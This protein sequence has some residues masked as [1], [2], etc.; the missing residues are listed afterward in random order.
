MEK[1][2]IG[3]VISLCSG[4]LAFAALG[5]AEVREGSVTLKTY[6]FSDPDPVPA[7]ME[8]RYPYFRFD[9]SSA[10]GRPHAFSTVHMENRRISLDLMPDVG[11]KVW[12]ATDKESGFD[13]IYRNHAAKF[14]NIATRGPWWSGGIEYNFGIIGHSPCTSTPVDYVIR[15][16]AD[17]SVSCIIAMT[18]FIC[19]TT[20]QVEVRLG[21]NDGHFT[22]RTLW[23]NA[24]GLPAPCYHWMNSA[25]PVSDDMVLKFDGRNEIGHEGDAHPWPID[26]E[27]RRLSVY[28]NNAFGHNK[29]YHVINGDNRVF[30]VWYPSRQIGFIHENEP[31]EK[32]GRKAWLWALSREGAIWEDLLTDFDGQY[33]ELQSGR[34]FN[35]PRLNTV[36]TPFKHPT[37]TPGR[38]DTFVEKWGVVRRE[39]GYLSRGMNPPGAAEPRPVTAP[40]DFDWNGV[41]GHFLR[42]QQAIRERE[43]R[44]GERELCASLAIDPNFVPALDELAFL[45]IRRGRYVEAQ[46]L[47]VRSL[48]VDT[49]GAAANYAAGFAAKLVGDLA[50]AKERLGL[51][52]YSIEYRNAAYALLARIAI[53]ESDWAGAVALSDRVLESDGANR[54][55]LLIRAIA[56]RLSG[57]RIEAR[58]AAERALSVWPLYF[59]A[60]YEAR[61][62]GASYDYQKSL[63]NEF[64]AETL[65]EIASW[66]RETGL[67]GDARAFETAA[68]EWPLAKIRLGD[69]AV[70]ASMPIPS[71]FP[72]RREDIPVL[73]RAI[74]ANSSWKFRYYR[75]A[76]A[77]SFQDDATAERLLDEIGET[78]DEWS[79]YLFR[80]AYRNGERRLADLKKAEGMSDDWRIGRAIAAYFAESCA[81]EESAA[82]AKRFL[83]LNPE[84]NPLQIAYAKALNGCK[85]WRETIEF[86]KHVRILPS[87]FGDNATE[88]WQVAQ[89]ALGMERTWPE[90]LGLGKPYD[91]S[92][93]K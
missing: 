59:A 84:N 19:R 72:F 24:S 60:M 56:L 8:K 6:P 46:E 68:G 25:S 75:A 58:A 82:A 39:D 38:T 22:T 34:A 51:A 67:E 47:S 92:A 52:S 54:D 66:Y 30:G 17:G 7:T 69:Y 11:G 9:G 93:K 86:L 10:E 36:R 80:A 85:R 76:L 1:K 87:E 13:F 26:A 74:A 32:Y 41:Y 4:L 49:Y 57:R 91:L 23:F 78:A 12:G 18:E 63:R 16:N 2:A 35:Q 45:A 53:M 88:S 79:F 42:G 27:G 55:G 21:M 81:W 14:R 31:Y 37:F 50:T 43:D 33:V 64:P 73:D 62:D 89:E 83:A 3:R 15:T 5:G 29:S 61:L 40:A 20:Y 65:L 90:N 71:V 77:A 48:S 28:A 44:L 70:A